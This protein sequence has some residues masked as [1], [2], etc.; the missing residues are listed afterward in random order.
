[1]GNFIFCAVQVK[2]FPV[3][4]PMKTETGTH[5]EIYLFKN[6]FLFGKFPKISTLRVISGHYFPVF[7]TEITPYLNTFHAVYLNT[8][9]NKTISRLE[10]ITYILSTAFLIWNSAAKCSSA[11]VY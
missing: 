10:M 5:H 9:S 1:M 4:P 11:N 7:G 2:I 8:L 6:F 3:K